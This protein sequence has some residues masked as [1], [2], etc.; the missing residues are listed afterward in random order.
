MTFS[1]PCS[2]LAA[3]RPDSIGEFVRTSSAVMLCH[4]GRITLVP[5]ISLLISPSSSFCGH[6]LEKKCLLNTTIPY[7][8]CAKPSSILLRRLSPSFSENTSYHTDS[9]DSR[10]RCA[11]GSTKS[12][13]SSLAWQIKASHCLPSAAAYAFFDL[14]LSKN[15]SSLLI[16]RSQTNRQIIASIRETI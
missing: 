4:I 8:D 10:N 13:L 2:D 9:P 3:T 1:R 11:N 7:R 6:S 14:L 16:A 15:V 5:A 12:F